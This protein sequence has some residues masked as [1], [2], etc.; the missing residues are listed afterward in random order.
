VDQIYQNLL[1]EISRIPL[2]DT[3][4][5]LLPEHEYLTNNGGFFSLFFQHYASSDLISA[6]MDIK[7]LEYLRT[8]DDSAGKKWEKFSPFWQN[9]EN[10][11][12]ARVIKIA[13]KDLFNIDEISE[14][15]I[16]DLCKQIQAKNKPGWYDYV[17]REKAGIKKVF[18][19]STIT[20]MKSYPDYFLP[21]VASDLFLDIRSAPE[22]ARLEEDVDIEIHSFK[23]LID[24]IEKF[25]TEAKQN[26]AIGIKITQAYKRDLN[27]DKRTFFEAELAFN[28]I[29]QGMGMVPHWNQCAGLSSEERKPL[30]DFLMHTIIR[31]AGEIGLVVQIHTGFQEG[32]GNYITNSN[33]TL[34]TNLFLEYHK[35]RFDIL[36]CGFPYYLELACLAKN[37]TN[38][39]PNMTW[40][41]CIG[42]T[43]ARRILCD[44]LDIIPINKI[45]GFG[46]DYHF[47]EG[48][49]GHAQLAHQSI[50]RVLS[51]KIAE[52]LYT[53]KQALIYG[54][55][56]LS[57]NAEVVYNTL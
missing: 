10:T 19:R 47:V 43:V 13:A 53:E 52:G 35:T 34:L 2:V 8:S 32:Q 1:P 46:G 22:I 50:A 57:E 17:L 21:I 42:S 31:L 38:V 39:Y 25:Y 54:Q 56:I 11:S 15:T 48:V 40:I 5:H 26:G 27:F 7:T 49:Y 41:Y 44:W 16:G 33:P 9:M 55:K 28:K 3:H 51:E 12:F 24:T 20:N 30:I 36:H 37:F 23:D 18:V 29:F 4:E 45:L 6:G 14:D